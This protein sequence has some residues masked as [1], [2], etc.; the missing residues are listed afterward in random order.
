MT[1]MPM[2]EYCYKHMVPALP[3][4]ENDAFHLLHQTCANS[5]VLAR[6][7]NSLSFTSSCAFFRTDADL[8]AFRCLAVSFTEGEISRF[9][10]CL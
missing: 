2:R 5:T 8:F 1:K 10:I 6:D 7:S 3:Y 4:Y 9:M